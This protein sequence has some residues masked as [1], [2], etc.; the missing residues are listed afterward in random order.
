MS[1]HRRGSG[2]GGR[3][4]AKEIVEL[5]CKLSDVIAKKSDNDQQLIDATKKIVDL[6]ARLIAVTLVR[7]QLEARLLEVR[8][9]LKLRDIEIGRLQQTKRDQADEILALDVRLQV[10]LFSLQ[11]GKC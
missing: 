10:A 6:E 7:D 8:E 2:D 5:K 4:D 11:C 9:Q 1:K 3:E